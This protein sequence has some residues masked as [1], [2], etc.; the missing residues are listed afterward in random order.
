MVGNKSRWRTGTQSLWGFFKGSALESHFFVDKDGRIEQYVAGDRTADAN[1]RANSWALSIETA[2][3]GNPDKTPWT[4]QQIESLARILVWANKFWGVPLRLTQNTRDSGV[5][6]HSS[7]GAPSLWT[8]ARGKTCPGVAR[9][10]QIPDVIRLA[11][12]LKTRDPN[13]GSTVRE[14]QDY[15][16][17]F[18]RG[19]FSPKLVVDGRWGPKTSAAW[20]AVTGRYRRR[21]EETLPLWQEP[22][23]LVLKWRPVWE[24]AAK[25][26]KKLE[27]FKKDV[28]R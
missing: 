24:D 2:D 27:A 12:E 1:F 23:K 16:N 20:E 28:G 7:H 25:H 8:P 4:P 15:L 13:G 18:N 11:N 6:G 22:E 17:L 10:K 26:V 21:E 19:D 5:N 9:K 3:D 14:L